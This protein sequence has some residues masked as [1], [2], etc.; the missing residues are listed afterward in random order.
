MWWVGG[1]IDGDGCVV[2]EKGSV[3][4]CMGKAAKGKCALERMQALF[5]GY[6]Y[7]HSQA[8][9]KKQQVF[10]WRLRGAAAAKTCAEVAPYT[11]AKRRQL[12]IAG[13]WP[14]LGR[15]INV[16]ATSIKLCRAELQAELKLLKRIEHPTVE[17]IPPDA[18]FAGF[19]DAEGC[20]MLQGMTLRLQVT[21]KYKA[22]LVAFQMRFGGSVYACK[23]KGGF[24]YYAG[25]SSARCLSTALMPH[26]HEKLEQWRLITQRFDDPCIGSKIAALKGGRERWGN[27][28]LA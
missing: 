2:V 20:I 6:I 10:Q 5:G 12:E 9:S 16:D 8:T 3:C 24:S 13:A 27:R 7:N 23:C 18:Y 4:L 1:Q 28:L 25:G 21:Q 26:A 22:V 14:M 19:F 15:G 17:S 11:T